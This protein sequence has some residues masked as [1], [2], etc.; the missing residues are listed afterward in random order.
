MLAVIIVVA[1][2]ALIGV[3]LLRLIHSDIIVVSQARRGSEARDTADAAIQEVIN[4]LRLTTPGSVNELPDPGTPGLSLAYTPPNFINVGPAP[5]SAVRSQPTYD[6]NA[7]I[8]LLRN[9]RKPE[10]QIT[11]VNLV[12]EIDVNSTYG[13]G[14]ATSRATAE[15]YRTVVY[16]A[17][18]DPQRRYYR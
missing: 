7:N 3:S 18:W 15:V 10:N 16:P 4:D 5:L 9:T 17:G 6:Y 12:Y 1:L 11:V 14:A 8:R 2:L 13:G